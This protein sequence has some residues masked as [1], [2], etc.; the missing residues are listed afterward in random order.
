MMNLKPNDKGP[1][2]GKETGVDKIVIGKSVLNQ[3]F[4]KDFINYMKAQFFDVQTTEDGVV[5]KGDN[6]DKYMYGLEKFL[7]PLD[8]KKKLELL[9]HYGIEVGDIE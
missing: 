6:L 9:E 8:E 7:Q 5:I 3:E 2:T 4:I 1:A